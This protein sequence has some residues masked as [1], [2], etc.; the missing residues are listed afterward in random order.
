MK[1]TC[2]NDDGVGDMKLVDFRRASADGVSGNILINTKMVGLEVG[3]SPQ[4]NV[5]QMWEKDHGRSNS[6]CGKP[7]GLIASLKLSAILDF[8]PH[9][10]D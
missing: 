3:L 9:D 1:S 2:C 10:Y 8:Q 6:E 7:C 5:D 4:L